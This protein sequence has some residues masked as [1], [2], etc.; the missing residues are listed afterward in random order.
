MRV[1]IYLEQ[2]VFVGTP[3]QPSPAGVGILSTCQ[4]CTA[5]LDRDLPAQ[6]THVRGTAAL[7]LLVSVSVDLP[8]SSDIFTHS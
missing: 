8:E 3:A 7:P 5:G 2:P 4:R 6:E 1:E